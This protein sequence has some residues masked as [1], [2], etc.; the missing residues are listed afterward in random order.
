MLQV[1]L[2]GRKEERSYGFLAAKCL[3]EMSI[4]SVKALLNVWVRYGR[5]RCSKSHVCW[6]RTGMMSSLMN[7]WSWLLCLSANVAF[8]FLFLISFAHILSYKSKEKY[9]ATDRPQRSVSN[10]I[11]FLLICSLLSFRFL[12]IFF[13]L[14]RAVCFPFVFPSCCLSFN[15]FL[16][17]FGFSLLSFLLSFSRWLVCLLMILL[18]GW[19]AKVFLFS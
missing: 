11:F 8:S 10:V 17:R 2:E 14:S 13:L 5:H 19:G 3:S 12:L 9:Y 1:S 16:S 18:F 4:V 15:I 6:L 7:V